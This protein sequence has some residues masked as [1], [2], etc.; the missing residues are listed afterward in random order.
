M[1]VSPTISAIADRSIAVNG[2]TGVIP[3]TISSSGTAVTGHSSNTSL[4]PAN[5]IV[6]GGSG[7]ARNVTVTPLAGQSGTTAIT[8]TVVNGTDATS[9]AFTLN[10][11]NSIATNPT[12]ISY[13]LGS[14][15]LTLSWPSDHTGWRLLVQ[16]NNLGGGISVNTNDWTTVA[17]SQQTNQVVLP[18][19]P[20]LPAAFYR[21]VYP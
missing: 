10:V 5:N 8:V 4:V 19:N 16:T 13:A 6:F 2:T 9:T 11:T 14:G 15:N 7:T 3:F 12:N 18:V 21:L 1:S 20:T 17:N